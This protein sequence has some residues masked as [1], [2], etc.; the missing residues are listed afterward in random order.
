MW[1]KFL[2]QVYHSGILSWLDYIT[3][4]KLKINFALEG[5]YSH[6][7][8]LPWMSVKWITEHNSYVDGVTKDSTSQVGR[9]LQMTFS[10][11][12]FMTSISCCL[13]FSPL[14]IICWFKIQN[15]NTEIVC[16]F[17]TLNLSS[18]FLV[19][20]RDNLSSYSH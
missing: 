5:D 12:S 7:W 15:K 19:N 2:L 10:H 13:F 9:S 8:H 4:M 16:F 3:V 20:T 14:E 18:F 11:Y 1:T 17:V 6:L